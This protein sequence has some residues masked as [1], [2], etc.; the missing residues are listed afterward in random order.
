MEHPV[1]E[2]QES[3]INVDR[4]WDRFENKSGDSLK[5]ASNLDF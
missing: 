3:M 4:I 2:L 5:V 1:A